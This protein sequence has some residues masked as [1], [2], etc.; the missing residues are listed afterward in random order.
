MAL[1]TVTGNIVSVNAIQGTLIADNAITAVHIATNAVSGT[2]I[3][4]NAVTAVHIA[5][6]TITVTQLADDCVESDKIA[7]GIITTNHLNKAMISSQTEVTAATGDF[8]LLGDTSDSNNLKK[9]PLSSI[10]ALSAV[11]T[12]DIT[13]AKIADDAVTGAKIEN[14]VTIATSVTSPLVDGQNFKVNGGQGSD[15]QVLTSTGSGVAWEDAAGGVDGVVSNADAT[16]I[17]I[18]SAEKVGIGASQPWSTLHVSNTGWSSGAPY[19]TIAT[20]EGNNVNDNNWGHLVVTDTTTSNGNGGSIRFASGSTS[21]LNPFAGIQGVA[22]GTSYGGVG[23]YTRASG[24]TATQ[25]MLINSSGHTLPGANNTYDLGA[26]ATRWR[27]IY[28]NDLQLSNEGGDSNEVDGTTGSWTIQEGSDNLFI[29]NR[30][31]GK[32]YKFLLEEV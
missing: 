8:V 22:E 4:D 30:N 16:A 5:Q 6:N 19:G 23:I 13:T 17:T 25:R 10:A 11:G 15:G 26:T 1:T 29:I 2:L 14:A 3:A 32:K 7:D 24:G 28:T 20:I 27:N 9:T 31:T 21:S 12:G 18:D